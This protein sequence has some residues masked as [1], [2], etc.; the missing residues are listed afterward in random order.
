MDRVPVPIRRVLDL[1]RLR[2]AFS[3][4]RWAREIGKRGSDSMAL[5]RRLG[6]YKTEG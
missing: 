1:Q 3:L 5:R 6:N 4:R 2:H